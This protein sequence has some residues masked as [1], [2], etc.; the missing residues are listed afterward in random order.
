M[1]AEFFSIR[2]H[3]TDADEYNPY[4]VCNLSNPFSLLLTPPNT[5]N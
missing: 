1:V 4:E 2:I 5:K 3:L